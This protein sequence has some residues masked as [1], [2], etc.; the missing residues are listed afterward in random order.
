MS[1]KVCSGLLQGCC[2][3]A[4]PVR[5][6]VACCLSN[7]S[8]DVTLCCTYVTAHPPGPLP[9]QTSYLDTTCCS[10][11]VFPS[12]PLAPLTSAPH[13][14]LPPCPPTPPPPPP[15]TPASDLLPPP[16]PQILEHKPNAILVATNAPQAKQIKDDM[17]K[18]SQ[19]TESE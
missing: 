7:A 2:W 16:L 14:S 17:E 8:V 15:I 12:H 13:L 19:Y 3:L 5:P 1:G 9:L 4:P 6:F 10:C 18:I 11:P